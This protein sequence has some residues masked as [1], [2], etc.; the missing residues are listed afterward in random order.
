M[1]EPVPP[2]SQKRSSNLSSFGA[3]AFRSVSALDLRAVSQGTHSTSGHSSSSESDV[4]HRG[5]QKQRSGLRWSFLVLKSE[6]ESLKQQ[7]AQAKAFTKSADNVWHQ[8]KLH[9]AAQRGLHELVEVLVVK[10]DAEDGLVNDFD[11]RGWTAL[12]YAV[13]ERRFNVVET[14]LQGG[15]QVETADSTALHHAVELGSIE[16]IDFIVKLRP[17]S[18]QAVDE[19]KRTALELAMIKDLPDAVSSFLRNGAPVEG[20]NSTILHQALQYNTVAMVQAILQARPD[21]LNMKDEVGRTPLH[22]A[23]LGGSIP[24]MKALIK[25]G[26]NLN[27]TTDN[28]RTALHELAASKSPQKDIIELLLHHT[29]PQTLVKPDSRGNT[30]IHDAFRCDNQWLVE[31][32]TQVYPS[33]V[34]VRNRTGT[35]VL[36]QAVLQRKYDCAKILLKASRRSQGISNDDWK[37]LLMK[38][39]PDAYIF[40]LVLRYSGSNITGLEALFYPA[41]GVPKILELLVKRG[42]D[43]NTRRNGQ[44]LLHG[45]VRSGDTDFAIYL[46]EFGADV[47]LADKT[48]ETPLIAA[49]LRK[50]LAF[51]EL[52]LEYGANPM[53]IDAD[54]ATPLLIAVRMQQTK[55]AELLLFMKP[56]A[57]HIRDS[58]KRTPLHYAASLTDTT[59]LRRFLKSLTAEHKLL[60]LEQSEQDEHTFLQVA[61]RA[62]QEKSVAALLDNFGHD[63]IVKELTRTGQ[64]TALDYAVAE[65]H[66]RVAERLLDAGIPCTIRDS[67]GQTALH[68]ALD[69]DETMIKLLYEQIH[70]DEASQELNCELLNLAIEKKRHWAVRNLLKRGVPV[71]GT[72][73]RKS[74]LHTAIECRSSVAIIELLFEHGGGVNEEDSKGDTPLCLAVTKGSAEISKFLLKKGANPNLPQT[75]DQKTPAGVA[76]ASGRLPLVRILMDH[77][78][79]IEKPRAGE[80]SALRLAIDEGDEDF[81]LSLIEAGASVDETDRRTGST[82]LHTAASKGLLRVVGALL[83]KGANPNLLDA[84]GQGIIELCLFE[85][86]EIIPICLQHNLNPNVEIDIKGKVVRELSSEDEQGVTLTPLIYAARKRDHATMTALLRAGAW[87][88]VRNQSGATALLSYVAE[89]TRV[90]AFE[91]ESRKSIITE[92]LKHGTDPNITTSNGM[93]AHV[94]AALA[95]DLDVLE[96]LLES[97]ICNPNQTIPQ[98]G[99]LTLLHHAVIRKDLRMLEILT[100]TEGCDLHVKANNGITALRT[101]LRSGFS[102]G[103]RYLLTEGDNEAQQDLTAHLYESIRLA[104]VKGVNTAFELGVDVDRHLDETSGSAT[105]AAFRQFLARP[106]RASD[107]IC[108][109]ILKHDPTVNCCPDGEDEAGNTVLHLAVR[110]EGK[111]GFRFVSAIFDLGKGAEALITQENKEGKRPADFLR[112]GSPILRF[113]HNRNKKPQRD[114]KIHSAERPVVPSKDSSHGSM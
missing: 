109:T 110:I 111:V 18:M 46:L 32:L 12:Q 97:G 80:A 31:R 107:H 44:T 15:A 106:S 79:V 72:G 99:N 16:M 66:T 75:R 98:S 112:A 71:K 85:R 21:S 43:V 26:A 76:L 37:E 49:V 14:L 3:K 73:P 25:A 51:V 36:G 13:H 6:S 70:S 2:N 54:G 50:S 93:T 88:N 19:A 39:I 77:G 74:A 64:W 1:F 56:D 86:P 100:A 8:N 78:A 95:Q 83:N 84:R 35:S 113:L 114:S 104:N 23:A 40:D 10:Q 52:V 62:G 30:P 55:I 7:R 96:L 28:G 89:T 24:A 92:L 60:L 68:R 29:K 38:A 87:P 5:L 63:L 101:A 102:D 105:F 82:L 17:S 11:N 57:V 45:A 81:A 27:A 41:K 61:S 58:N 20:Y 94:A 47:N 67:R 91:D 59:I 103:A 42:V 4:K 108:I 90:R 53:V 34:H 48:K 22:M 65:N 33:T 69:Q 9:Y